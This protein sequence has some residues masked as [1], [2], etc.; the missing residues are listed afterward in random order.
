MR[1]GR[2]FFATSSSGIPLNR[3][4]FFRGLSVLKLSTFSLRLRGSRLTTVE[5]VSSSS[6]A[7]TS[8]SSSSSL[9]SHEESGLLKETAEAGIN[10][11]SVQVDFLD[12]MSNSKVFVKHDIRFLPYTGRVLDLL[13]FDR[14]FAVITESAIVGVLVLVGLEGV[15]VWFV[16]VQIITVTIFLI[17][18]VVI[19]LTRIVGFGLSIAYFFTVVAILML[20]MRFG[21]FF[22]AL[23]TAA[24]K[25][26]GCIKSLRKQNKNQKY[27]KTQLVN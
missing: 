18:I 19:D 5:E 1:S 6:S 23:N 20:I 15:G 2:S 22:F 8:L 13:G 16:F 24:A 14:L 3:K 21:I 7:M 11:I 4:C 27:A 9:R 12:L 26:K 17:V 10:Q 25:N